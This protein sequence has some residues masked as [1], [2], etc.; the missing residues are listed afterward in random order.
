MKDG[1]WERLIEGKIEDLEEQVRALVAW[2]N[3]LLGLVAGMG[4]LVGAFAR[5]VAYILTHLS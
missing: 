5:Q 1:G 2:R 4:L 3:W